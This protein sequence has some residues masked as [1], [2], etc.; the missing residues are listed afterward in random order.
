M[1]NSLHKSSG[2]MLAITLPL[3]GSILAGCPPR[4]P[5]PVVEQVEPP[6]VT[7]QKA[8]WLQYGLR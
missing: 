7:S 8:S 4:K 1:A 5:T 2:K 6:T 3:L